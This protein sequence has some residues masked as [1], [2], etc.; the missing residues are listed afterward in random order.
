MGRGESAELERLKALAADSTQPRQALVQASRDCTR[1]LASPEPDSRAAVGV[2]A[3]LLARLLPEP[4]QAAATVQVCESGDA[5]LAA[6]SLG[7]SDD[8]KALL[9]PLAAL[10]PSCRFAL[11]AAV[12]AEEEAATPAPLLWG[13]LRTLMTDGG[14]DAWAAA[15][16]ITRKQRAD[17]L[18]LW[19]TKAAAAAGDAQQELPGTDAAAAILAGWLEECDGQAAAASAG[20]G[21]AHLPNALQVRLLKQAV[22]FAAALDAARGGED[23]GAAMMM[24][25]EMLRDRPL[26]LRS[27]LDA[28]TAA[29]TVLALH[30]KKK[31]TPHMGAVGSTTRVR[32]VAP[33]LVA[34]L[35]HFITTGGGDANGLSGAAAKLLALLI[36]DESLDI[37][38][39]T[40]PSDTACGHGMDALCTTLLQ[41]AASSHGRLCA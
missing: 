13:P 31:N 39:S 26:Q 16:G 20:S 33:S 41:D 11:C 37:S 36:A 30:A 10:R 7:G 38:R 4:L 6:A 18:V 8:A 14:R 40:S 19:L 32:L 27:T 15:G 23:E 25:L 35:I 12:L 21:A 5:E 3:R 24:V 2:L 17:G 28:W 1:V 9:A 22:S 34:D 29:V